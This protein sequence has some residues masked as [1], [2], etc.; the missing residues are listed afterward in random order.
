MQGA[1]QS[2]VA[3]R[4]RYAMHQSMQESFRDA[5]EM[6]QKSAEFDMQGHTL[7][8]CCSTLITIIIRECMWQPSLSLPMCSNLHQ[9]KTPASPDAT[10]H[11]APNH[12]H[13]PVLL[14]LWLALHGHILHLRTFLACKCNLVCSL[15]QIKG[16]M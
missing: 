6:H 9:M 8:I 7:T 15:P 1:V 14:H 3:G 12:H 5:S 10:S 4:V 13:H 2:C 11:L 16:E